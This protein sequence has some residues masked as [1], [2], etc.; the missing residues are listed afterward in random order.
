MA[1][2]DVACL[3]ETTKAM[4]DIR[5]AIEEAEDPGYAMEEIAAL[6]D[7]RVEAYRLASAAQDLLDDLNGK[8]RKR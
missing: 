4:G 1:Q 2:I 3:T 5:A 6:D 7:L 8:Q